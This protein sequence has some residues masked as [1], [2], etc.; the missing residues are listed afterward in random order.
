MMFTDWV[1]KILCKQ[2]DEP[3][4][5][6]FIPINQDTPGVF[7]SELRTTRK[8]DESFSISDCQVWF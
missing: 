4:G 6:Y 7:L 8:T 2:Q 5:Q 1:R 3:P